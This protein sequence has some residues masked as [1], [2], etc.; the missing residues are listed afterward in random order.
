[1]TVR[2][3]PLLEP[4]DDKWAGT[5]NYVKAIKDLRAEKDIE[6]LGLGPGFGA[7]SIDQL[8]PL[9]WP[10]RPQEDHYK[11]QHVEFL[12]DQSADLLDRGIKDRSQWEDLYEKWFRNALE[13][14][15]L[16]AIDQV[17]RQEEEAG[18]F[19]VQYSL[20][21][22]EHSANAKH[23]EMLKAACDILS[24]LC[25]NIGRGSGSSTHGPLGQSIIENRATLG[26][27]YATENKNQI[28][29]IS[30]LLAGAELDVETYTLMAQSNS[31]LA[32]ILSEQERAAGLEAKKKFESDNRTIQKE[33]R[34][35]ARAL[36]AVKQHASSIGNGALDYESRMKPI[37]QRYENDFREA[38]ARIQIAARGLVLLYG[39]KDP[40]PQASVDN[41]LHFFDD[42]LIWVRKSINHLVRFQR[43]D[44]SY[45][46][47]FSLKT[48]C[49]D[50]WLVSRTSGVFRFS[51][52]E[53]DF[54]E[55]WNQLYLR[56]RGMSLC[57]V[58]DDAGK[59]TWE[60]VIRA[61]VS[62]YCFHKD[63]VRCD[64]DQKRAASCLA[65]RVT[66]RGNS[67]Q[68][69]VIGEIE[70]FNLSP[71]GNWEIVTGPKSLEGIGRETLDDVHFDLHLVA[72]VLS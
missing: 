51:L 68:P 58:G 31:L 39:Y 14:K 56:L 12:L 30:R 46:L 60:F 3:G 41:G 59:G 71:F 29:G 70:F 2:T 48:L 69:E 23:T 17:Q 27:A 13:V 57:A 55:G 38:L 28:E 53:S 67:P 22:G 37:Q 40:L 50:T 6:N 44:Q 11:Y 32:S 49:R 35:I 8:V 66:R 4:L 43:L 24:R 7:H 10:E 1:M 20:S 26:A 52:T 72:R 62:S 64:L 36:A 33:R 61:P 65:G 42:C 9:A 34:N 21:E 25:Q 15:E 18:I 5:E 63:H 45:I 16:L 19:E 54:P 47:S